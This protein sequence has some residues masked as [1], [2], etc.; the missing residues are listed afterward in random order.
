MECWS[1]CTLGGYVSQTAHFRQHLLSHAPQEHPI[2]FCFRLVS[3]V[4]ATRWN[5]AMAW[6]TFDRSA[7]SGLEAT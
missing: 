7:L 4:R 5:K 3:I 6:L 1:P 2:S